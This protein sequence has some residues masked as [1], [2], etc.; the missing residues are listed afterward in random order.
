MNKTVTYPLALIAIA[1]GSAFSVPSAVAAPAVKVAA[2][3][4]IACRPGRPETANTCRHA[5][6]A[7][8]VAALNPDSLWLAGDSQYENG[9]FA[10]YQQSFGVSWGRFAPIWRPV[11]GNHEY[12]SN[13]AWGFFDYFGAA[14]GPDRRGYYSFTLG[15]WKVVAINTNCDRVACGFNSK[16]NRWLRR[17]LKRAKNECVAAITHHPV[18]S[19]GR[20]GANPMAKPLFKELRKARV[21]FAVAGHEHLYERLMPT[22]EDGRPSKRRGMPTFITGAG[23][24]NLYE[25]RNVVPASAY[26]KVDAFGVVEFTLSKGR[27]S[28]R[29][30]DEFG[31]S[32]DRGSARCR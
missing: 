11:P 10:N 14:A 12:Y 24:K 2:V 31:A 32:F 13:G 30:V 3:G 6:V 27:Y 19:S 22:L 8:R 1:L 18:I 7:D 25:F 15:S 26:R 16:Q 29:F 17:E 4:D 28:W 9:E 5:K 23:G 21:E 20:Y